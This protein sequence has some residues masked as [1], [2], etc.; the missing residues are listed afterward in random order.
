MPS[1]QNYFRK[2]PMPE[3]QLMIETHD[4]DNIKG[5]K[6]GN[7]QDIFLNNCRKNEDDVLIQTIDG[8][9]KRGRIVGFDSQTVILGEGSWQQLIYKSG[10]VTISP[11]REVQYIFSEN[12]HML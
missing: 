11:E 3:E 9:T 8:S 7:L 5:F 6:N 4:R 2:L 1:Q 12:R 10:V